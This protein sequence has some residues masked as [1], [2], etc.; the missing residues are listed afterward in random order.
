MPPDGMS[1]APK[2][3]ALASRLQ[4]RAASQPNLNG[5]E[6]QNL[7]RIA[8]NLLQAEG[9]FRQL[10]PGQSPLAPKPMDSGL[11]LPKDLGTRSQMKG[12]TGAPTLKG[13]PPPKP[14]KPI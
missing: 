8:N 2:F 9:K 6:R 4:T 11:Q 13:S 12:E 5:S 7:R 3:H 1:Q 10:L 14:A